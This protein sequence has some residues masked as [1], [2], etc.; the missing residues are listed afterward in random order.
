MGI[1]NGGEKARLK[2]REP[3]VCITQQY[4]SA[5]AFARTR[6]IKLLNGS[7]L[8]NKTVQEIAYEYV[9]RICTIVLQ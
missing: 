2:L 6:I 5:T 8:S 4:N 9:T 7:V 3:F 1:Q